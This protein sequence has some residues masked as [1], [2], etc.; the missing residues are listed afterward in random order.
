MDD[1]DLLAAAEAEMP[2]ENASDY[3]QESG[4]SVAMMVHKFKTTKQKAMADLKPSELSQIEARQKFQFLDEEIG[5]MVKRG[6]VGT[7]V[8]DT[9]TNTPL[10][11]DMEFISEHKKIPEEL[12]EG[13]EDSKKE[14]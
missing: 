4:D 5:N 14:L 11:G 10:Q 9:K 7:P 13:M 1:K 12:K 2:T 8:I 6:D 3:L